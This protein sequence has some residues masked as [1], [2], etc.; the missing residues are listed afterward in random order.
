M[1]S[2]VYQLVKSTQ[3]LRKIMPGSPN[4]SDKFQL[5]NLVEETRACAGI[6]FSFFLSF[7]LLNNNHRQDLPVLRT[8]LLVVVVNTIITANT[9]K[10]RHYLQQ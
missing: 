1:L 2:G 10:L 7:L 4:T 5:W 3:N 9:D 8:I 6:L